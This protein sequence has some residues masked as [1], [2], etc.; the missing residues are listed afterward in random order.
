MIN[1]IL[2]KHLPEAYDRYLADAVHPFSGFREGE[3][4]D[5]DPIS[6]SYVLA[7]AV[8]YSGRGT[9]Q[10]YESLELQ[11][12]EIDI[13]DVK[14]SCLQIECSGTPEIGDIITLRDRDHRIM[15]VKPSGT[16]L[17]WIMQLRGLNVV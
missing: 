11:V 6:D 10:E 2:N 7:P 8:T 9:I 12:T 13:T 1:A 3:K 15:T 16:D 4:G 14:F 17:K 5:Y